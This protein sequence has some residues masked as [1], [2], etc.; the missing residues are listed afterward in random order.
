M[1]NDYPWASFSQLYS[2]AQDNPQLMKELQ[3]NLDKAVDEG[4][5]EAKEIDG[6]LKYRFT[7]LGRMMISNLRAAQNTKPTDGN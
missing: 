7:D 1:I 6:Q 4:Y 3:L 5:M 2:T